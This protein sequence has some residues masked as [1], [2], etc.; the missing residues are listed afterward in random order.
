MDFLP[1]S[2][3][4]LY[5]GYFFNRSID[6]LPEKITHLICGSSFAQPVNKLPPNLVYFK[7]LALQ[8]CCTLPST[9]QYLFVQDTYEGEKLPDNLIYINGLLYHIAFIFSEK[10]RRKKSHQNFR[11]VWNLGLHG[12]P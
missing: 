10:K 5:L 7:N 3:I 9:I 4:Y 8:P 2:L 12:C 11:W 1:N 6:N